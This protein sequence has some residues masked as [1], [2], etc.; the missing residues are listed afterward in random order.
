VRRFEGAPK[1]IAATEEERSAWWLNEMRN[2][3][4]TVADVALSS[5]E[6][7]KIKSMGLKVGATWSSFK[8]K[9]FFYSALTAERRCKEL[10]IE[11]ITHSNEY[12]NDRRLTTAKIFINEKVDAVIG[13]DGHSEA[14]KLYN[15][16]GIPAF[17]EGN[18]FSGY[19][20]STAAVGLDRYA[21]G[22]EQIRIL[23]S[24]LAAEGYDDVTVATLDTPPG[25]SWS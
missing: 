1:P 13:Q 17:S 22:E 5:E 7:A 12:S 18:P 9:K 25:G 4:M 8:S 14:V 15:E 21:A 6:E 20:P 23:A 24:K 3:K 2:S 10:G 16:A 19:Y 11:L